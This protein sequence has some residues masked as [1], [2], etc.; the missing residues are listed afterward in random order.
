LADIVPSIVGDFVTSHHIAANVDL[1]AMDIY[2]AVDISV[3]RR[4][5]LI[6]RVGMEWFT[7]RA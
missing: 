2:S 6:R 3:W 5:T 4:I 7:H 1:T